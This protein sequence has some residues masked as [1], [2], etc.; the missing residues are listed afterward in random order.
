MRRATKE[1]NRPSFWTYL[2]MNGCRGCQKQDEEE[3]IHHVLLSGG[4]EGIG[5]NKNNRYRTEMRRAIGK[6]GKLMSDINNNEGTEQAANAFRALEWPRQQTD[7]RLRT[8]EELVLRQMISGIIPEWQDDDNKK[9]KGAIALF[10]SWTVDMMN[11]ARIQMKAWVNMK[12]EHK[13]CVQKRW[14]NRGKMHTTFHRW[15]KG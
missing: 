2:K 13:A 11:C 15:R 8:E 9:K 5:R 6:C 3:T 1:G 10:T 4:C 12:N 14:D 7:W